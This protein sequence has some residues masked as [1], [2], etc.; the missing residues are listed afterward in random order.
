M[1]GVDTQDHPVFIAASRGELYPNQVK[2]IAKEVHITRSNRK[3]TVLEI[4]LND[5]LGFSKVCIDGLDYDKKI[6]VQ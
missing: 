3:Q 4:C 5:L 1:G 6:I 2:K